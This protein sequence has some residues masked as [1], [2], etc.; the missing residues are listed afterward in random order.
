[1]LSSWLVV[2]E[3]NVGLPVPEL[4]LS[5]ISLISFNKAYWGIGEKARELK[6]DPHI[7]NA[8][9]VNQ[10]QDLDHKVSP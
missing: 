8:V 3:G 7:T 1:M 2:G 4:Y 6:G 5:W 10:A 9:S